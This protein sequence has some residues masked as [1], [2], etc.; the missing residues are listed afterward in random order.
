MEQSIIHKY[1]SLAPSHI[2]RYFLEN[3][4]FKKE[5]EKEP[6]TFIILGRCGPTGKTWLWRGLKSFGFN[7]FEP[8]EAICQCMNYDYC[9]NYNHVIKNEI[10]RSIIVILNQSLGRRVAL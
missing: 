6:Y 2:L 4:L 9:D 5:H 3:D 7:A 10:D 8:A 1:G